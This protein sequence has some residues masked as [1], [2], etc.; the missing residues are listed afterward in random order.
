MQR[1]AR[2][3]FGK[4]PGTPRGGISGRELAGMS[5]MSVDLVIR[6]LARLA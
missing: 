6:D 2:E 3:F 5:Q 1:A 4:G